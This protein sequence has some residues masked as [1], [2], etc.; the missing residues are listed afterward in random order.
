MAAPHSKGLTYFKVGRSSDV[1]KRLAGVQTG[2]P[3][4]ITKVYI[5]TMWGNGHSQSVEAMMHNDLAA[6]RT[7]GEWF[8]FSTDDLAHKKVMNDAMREAA[9]RAKVGETIPKWRNVPVAELKAAVSGQA[10]DMAN[11]RKVGRKSQ[12]RKAVVLMATTG[13]RIL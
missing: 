8:A 2:C 10:E 13:R 7:Q 1:A 11:E 6:Y 12:A 4:P 5:L 3:L 9:M